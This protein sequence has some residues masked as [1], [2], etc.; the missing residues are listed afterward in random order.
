VEVFADFGQWAIGKVAGQEVQQGATQERQVGQ[1]RGVAGTRAVFAHQ[2]VAP[3][4]VADFDP[5]PV[6]ADESQPLLRAVLIGRGAGQIVAGFAGGEA[7]LFDGSFAAQDDQGAGKGEV[8]GEGF[9]GEGV[10]ATDFDASVAR[11][12]VGKKGVPGI[13]SRRCACRCR[14]G[15]LPLIWR[16]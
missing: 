13:A 3:P 16:R 8:G 9:D 5:A 6:A 12:G 15:W 10:E 1:Q 14:R 4:V 11:L 7:G 2:G